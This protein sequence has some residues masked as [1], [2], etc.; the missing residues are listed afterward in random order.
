MHLGPDRHYYSVPYSYI[1]KKVR[2][3]FSKSFVEIYH[4][5]ELIASHPRVKSPHNYTT[6]PAH[7]AS[8]HQFVSDWSP[9]YFL[10]QAREISPDVEF[11]IAQV[12]LKKFIPNKLTE[13]VVEF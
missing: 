7:M 1:G 5:H 9:D 12:L 11:Y 13:P 10:K 3:L 2:L 8:Q 4:R 6:D